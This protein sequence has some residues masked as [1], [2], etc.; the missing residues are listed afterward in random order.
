MGNWPNGNIWRVRLSRLRRWGVVEGV[1]INGRLG[2]SWFKSVNVDGCDVTPSRSLGGDGKGGMTDTSL[3]VCF[4]QICS[5]CVRSAVCVSIHSCISTNVIWH[6]LASLCNSV[7]NCSLSEVHDL[8]NDGNS[9]G[10]VVNLCCRCFIERKMA[11]SC[12]CH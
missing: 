11:S 2:T 7:S 12:L 9:V 5:I 10:W 8:S 1:D 6:S 4:I 3:Q